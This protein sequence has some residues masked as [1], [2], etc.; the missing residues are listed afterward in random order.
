MEY[1]HENIYFWTACERYRKIKGDDEDSVKVRMAAAEN[2]LKKHLSAG[3]AE[4]VNV[5]SHARQAAHDGPPTAGL[6]ATAQ[7]Q[8]YNLMKFDSFSRFLKSDLYKDSL[9][10]EMSGKNLPFENHQLDP[11]LDIGNAN[12]AVPSTT[13]SLGRKSQESSRRRSILPAWAGNLRKDRSKSKDREN[14]DSQSGRSKM[15]KTKNNEQQ[16]Y[17][18]MTSLASTN[19]ED[20]FLDTTNESDEASTSS[21]CALARVILPD[22]ATTVVQTR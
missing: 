2:I 18:S 5:D 13:S 11:L 9:V 7:K 21:N 16:Q 22:K 20:I 4:P 3:A 14:Q 19:K 10:A 1:S 15:K 12:N 6:F 17:H 8:I